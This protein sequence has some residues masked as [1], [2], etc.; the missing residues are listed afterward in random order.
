M[1]RAKRIYVLLFVPLVL[2]IAA[3]AVLQTEQH[4]EQIKTSG[5]VVLQIDADMVQALSWE[6]DGQ[7][8]SFHKD[9]SWSYDGDA[10]FPVDDQKIASLLEQFEEFGALFH[11]L[12]C[13]GLRPIRPERPSVH[14][15]A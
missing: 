9:E 14:H 12:R 7:T 5:E 4:K 3:V 13:G 15:L 6:Y 11:H 1:N 8:L 10:A 2:C